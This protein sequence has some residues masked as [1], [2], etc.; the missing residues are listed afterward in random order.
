[1]S[2]HQRNDCVQVRTSVRRLLAASSL[3]TY[4]A[5]L[6]PAS[7]AQ[8]ADS[9]APSARDG[10]R[11]LDTILVEGERDRFQESATKSNLA[12]R[13]TPQAISIATRESIEARQARDLTSALELIAGLSSG[14]A[15]DGGPFAGRGLGGGEGFILRGQ[16]LDGKRDV[17]MDGFIVSSNVFDLAAFERV[18]VVKGPA[19]TLYGQGSLGGFINMI[20]KKPE[21][22]RSLSAVIQGGSFDTYRGE[23]DAT[24]ALDTNER[25]L[26]RMTLAYDD[27]DAFIDNVHTRT[28]VVAP[29]LQTQLGSNTRALV[30]FL[31]QDDE[32]TPSRGIPLRL[33]GR[34]TF[35]PRVSRSLFAGVPS[36]QES[37]ARNHLLTTQVDHSFADRWLASLLLQRGGQSR[38]RFFDSY[39]NN[40]YLDTSGDVNIYSDTSI[41]EDDNW[42][43]ELR[44]DGAFSAFGRTHR[45]LLGLERGERREHLA[46]GY[47]TL[48]PGN[49]YDQEFAA[50]AVLPGGAGNQPYDFDLR[51]RVSDRAAYGQVQ[52][53]LHERTRLL[54]GARY[55]H[56]DI[57]R[58]NENT[59][60]IDSKTDE[61]MTLRVGV[62][63]DVN[64]HITGY[65]T[66]AQ[67]FNPSVDARS[68]S[69]RILDPE[70]GEGLELGL[71]SEWAEG[72]FTASGAIF[73]QELDNRPIT[74]P[75]NRNFSINGG[76]QRTDGV[77]L[78]LSGSPVPGL[79]LGTAATWLDSEYIDPRDENFGFAPYGL[80]KNQYSFYGRYE[81]QQG[82]LRGLG[83]GTTL[84]SVGD[85][86]LF[87][88]EFMAGYE[89]LD[90]SLSYSGLPSW[91]VSLQV[92]NV[93]D[94]R[95]IERLRD[96]WQDN[97]FGSPRAVLVR[98]QYKFGL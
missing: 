19:S 82:L 7:V 48:G 70:T 5:T 18:E 49:I 89:R 32:Y 45:V 55:D 34:E 93:L 59:D 85:R 90:V 87:G 13:E 60:Q 72:R 57:W 15:A 26:G 39:S 38:E 54:V 42:A 27:S 47:A 96:R 1:V 20:R 8:E 67:S 6:P 79:T 36:Q 9:T 22:E 62:T 80:V 37:T 86:L 17:R 81:L 33:E 74:D 71:K 73:R 69:G 53:S 16:E 97:F 30:Q 91:D 84:I 44:L 61:E 68:E 88:D 29:S 64:A 11:T 63:H 94:E 10:S 2:K 3:A 66:Y 31:Y 21:A 76:L 24:G 50:D 58:R 98:M 41:T 95:Y 35:I 56:S 4:G 23:L 40:G 25:F 52:L 43:G 92:R 75:G 77:E 28:A 14:V 46:F 12:L 78:E 65:A 83:L 51:T